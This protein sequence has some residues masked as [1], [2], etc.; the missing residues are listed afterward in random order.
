MRVQRS[1]FAALGSPLMRQPLGGSNSTSAPDRALQPAWVL[2]D[3]SCGFC[4]RWVPFWE[5]TLMKRGFRIAPLQEAWVGPALALPDDVLFDDLRLLLPGGACLAGA[6]VYRYVMRRIW[7]AYPFYLLSTAPVL[8]GVFDWSYRTF[9]VNR[10]RISRSCRLP[11]GSSAELPR[12][13][14]GHSG[15]VEP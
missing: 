9:A 3:D 14:G 7:W 8:R 2:F 1:R 15:A 10:Y 5:T 11:G 4:R 13:A 6:N 12:S